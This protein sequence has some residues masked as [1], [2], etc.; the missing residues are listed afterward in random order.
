M[1]PGFYVA[2]VLFPVHPGQGTG[3][4]RPWCLPVRLGL[5]GRRDANTVLL[6]LASYHVPGTMAPLSLVPRGG[7]QG[8]SQG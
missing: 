1:Q 4:D 6:A 5:C 7:S 2:L 8:G 3:P